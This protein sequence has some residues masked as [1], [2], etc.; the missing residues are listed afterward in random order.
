M[1]CLWIAKDPDECQYGA[2]NRFGTLTLANSHAETIDE[3][4][5]Q[6]RIC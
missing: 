1:Y 3:S 2:A 4:L 5:G 6:V